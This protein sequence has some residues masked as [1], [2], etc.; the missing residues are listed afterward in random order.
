MRSLHS[1]S[2]PSCQPPRCPE[3]ADS[4]HTIYP[5]QKEVRLLYFAVVK[6]GLNQKYNFF[7]ATFDLRPLK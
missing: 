2:W 3:E 7:I 5:N 4:I 6:T 1:C